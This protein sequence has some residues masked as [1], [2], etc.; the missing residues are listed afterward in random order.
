MTVKARVVKLEH[1]AGVG[2]LCLDCKRHLIRYS[3][4]IRRTPRDGVLVTPCDGC[5]FPRHVILYGHTEREQE[6]L[7]ELGRPRGRTLEERR[8]RFTVMVYLMMTPRQGEIEAAG[9]AEEKRLRDI[10]PP[11]SD[12]RTQLKVLD[13]YG[14]V[15]ASRQA[16][17]RLLV[18]EEKDE[19]RCSRRA[20]LRHAM[21]VVE[22]ARAE[23]L[24][25]DDEE[26]YRLLVMLKLEP[27][28]FGD[29]LPETR[30][31][32]EAHEREKREAAE[33]REREERER[34]ERWERERLEREERYRL[35][36]EA[37]ERA[38]L[39]A[40]EPAKE[41]GAWL[42]NYQP[43]E[44]APRSRFIKAGVN[45]PPNPMVFDPEAAQKP[46]V[47]SLAGK[48]V[49]EAYDPTHPDA[50]QFQRSTPADPTR[51]LTID[52]LDSERARGDAARRYYRGEYYEGDRRY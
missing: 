48:I 13:E 51:G 28:L 22:E 18:S 40:T 24:K 33:A 50:V 42:R 12:V 9:D 45:I 52:D 29:A 7:R 6:L 27:Y 20:P 31:K 5:G 19:E 44:P 15:L 26:L 16:A 43:G 23:A 1:K 49:H 21:A 41:S 30:E 34:K 39:Q 36:R 8:R 35:E 17:R 4:I 46:D 25:A 2:Q 38:R 47:T 32:I 10:K 37:R 3:D 14:A 11:P